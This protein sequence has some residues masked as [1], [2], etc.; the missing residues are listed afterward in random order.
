M[1]NARLAD[2]HQYGK[3]LS[4]WLSLVMSFMVSLCTVFFPRDVLYDILDWI[5]SV[6]HP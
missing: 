3:L 5:E 2:D 4:T 1:L 6:Y